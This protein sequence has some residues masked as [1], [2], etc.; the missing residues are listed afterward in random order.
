MDNDTVITNLSPMILVTSE[1]N[2][3]LTGDSNNGMT[4]AYSWGLVLF[5]M[6]ILQKVG[7]SPSNT[8]SWAALIDDDDIDGAVRSPAAHILGGGGSVVIQLMT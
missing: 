4:R 8:I 6:L 1:E 5:E 7:R 2:A 3:R